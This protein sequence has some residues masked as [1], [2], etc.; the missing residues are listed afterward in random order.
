MDR[1][2]TRPDADA[3]VARTEPDRPDGPPQPG[4]RAARGLPNLGRM[5]LGRRAGARDRRGG[6]RQDLALAATR[7]RSRPR[8]PLG[9]RR[10]HPV[11]RTRPTFYRLIAR[12]FGL[13]DPAPSRVGLVDVLDGLRLD[14][15]RVGLVVEEAHNL[16]FDLWEE[17]RVLA[18]RLGRPGGFASMILVGQTPLALRFA[19]RPFAAIEARLAARVHLGPIERRRG[20]ATARPGPTRPFLDARRAGS[21]PPRRL[22]QPRE[23]APARRAAGRGDRSGRR[24]PPG[25]AL[26]GSSRGSSRLPVRP[27]GPIRADARVSPGPRDTAAHRTRPAAPLDRPGPAADP[28][29]REHDRGW[30]GRR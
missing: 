14:G 17:V 28:R 4:S 19:T 18:N 7:G 12:E 27:A 2:T 26:G 30:L 23:V 25:D 16:G 6:R 24:P 29:R 21:P 3:L 9:R 15:Q 8:P 13:G 22:G 1:P 20:P 11:T 5:P 10:P